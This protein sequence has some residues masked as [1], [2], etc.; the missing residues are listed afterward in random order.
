MTTDAKFW[1]RIAA[2]Y[3]K[4]PI[5]DMQAYEHK[6]GITRKFMTEDSS[7]VE[8][9]C[10]TGSTALLHA[11]YVKHILATDL[12][13]KM[14]EIARAKLAI[15]QVENVTFRVSS[16]EQLT[17]EEPVDMVM[18]MSLLHLVKDKKTVIKHIYDWL[19][20]GGRFVSTTVCMGEKYW[21][22]KY[23]GPIGQFFGLL[24]HLDI[25]TPEDLKSCLIECGFEIE[26]AW[27]PEKGPTV[28]YVARKPR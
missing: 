24:P 2:K 23:L 25:F 4:Q 18:A 15:D 6:L 17:L 13:P 27:R 8:I 10:G 11:P 19:K 28:F 16:V 26:Y 21:I 9:G 1:N 5:G 14:I 20:P 3:S 12:S 7:V 22:F